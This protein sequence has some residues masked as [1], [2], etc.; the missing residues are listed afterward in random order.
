MHCVAFLDIGHTVPVFV[1]V[2]L[3]VQDTLCSDNDE[4]EVL[5][6]SDSNGEVLI[7]QARLMDLNRIETE[8]AYYERMRKVV[9]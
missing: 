6:F 2:E 7:H 9:L 3:S 5:C 1:Y 4:K 8:D